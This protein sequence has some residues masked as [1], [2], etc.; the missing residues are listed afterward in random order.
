MTLGI[1]NHPFYHTNFNTTRMTL[2][3]Y[4]S[5]AGG[6]FLAACL[7]LSDCAYLNDENTVLPQVRGEM[8]QIMKYTMLEARM[9]QLSPGTWTDMG[10][11]FPPFKLDT[12]GMGNILHPKLKKYFRGPDALPMVVNSELSM[13]NE[14]AG[15]SKMAMQYAIWPNARTI[16]FVNSWPWIKHQ[17][18][19][20]YNPI[21]YQNW[22]QLNA[23]WNKLKQ[24]NWPSGPPVSQQD[25]NRH[26][27]S[28]IAIT[29]YH[30]SQVEQLLYDE[31]FL[32]DYH[33]IEQS[34]I[35]ELASSREHSIAWN[36]EWFQDRAEF[37]SQVEILYRYFGFPDFNATI[38]GK[39]Y[40]IW[41]VKSKD[42]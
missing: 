41:I 24:P 21:Q 5:G 19:R 29:D 6:K 2:V 22:S 38:V 16:Y 32:E 36:C 1:G 13:F 42:T 12:F 10:L 23:L 20:R 4:P 34:A 3:V 17:R 28:N 33:H 35:I 26:P 15:W 8:T 31:S 25:F 30:R 37:I 7:G 39:L 9:M 11:G 40:D 27:W 14:L 18:P